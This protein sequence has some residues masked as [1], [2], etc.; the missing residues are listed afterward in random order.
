MTPTKVLVAG[1]WHGNVRWAEKIIHDARKLPQP[2]II[3]QLGDFG[4]WQGPDGYKYLERV[5]SALELSDAE[6]WVTPGNHENYDL[7]GSWDWDGKTRVTVPQHP[8]GG[9]DG[10]DRIVCLGRGDRWEWH[11]KT[12]LS[13]G[14]AVSVDRL[15]PRPPR[16]EGKTWWPGEEVTDAEE[17]AIIA[18]GHADV[19]LAHDYPAGVNYQHDHHNAPHFHQ[20]DLA[21][22]EAHHDRMR[23]I[24]DAV[25]PDTYIHG[26][27][28]RLSGRVVDFGYG[29]VRVCSLDMD[30]NPGNACVLDTET[31]QW[32]TW[33]DL[34]DE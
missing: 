13:C 7:I 4:F 26:H 12:W 6:L 10:F 15:L 19:M 21:R 18:G 3:L 17:A 14:G 20:D 27:I 11:G 25:Q 24:V 9:K 16:V 28:H 32:L 5:Q 29:P 33:D 30:G 31:M 1:D 34:D 2:R 23:R 8:H 22:A